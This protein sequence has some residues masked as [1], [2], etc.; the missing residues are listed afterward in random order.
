M[1][2]LDDQCSK[3]KTTQLILKNEIQQI[4]E[5]LREIKA[6]YDEGCIKDIQQ[7]EVS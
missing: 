3:A 1:K 2:Q 7:M 4:K 6:T 5:R